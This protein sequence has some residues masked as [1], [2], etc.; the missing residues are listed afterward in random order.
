VSNPNPAVESP[1]ARPQ[2]LARADATDDKARWQAS[3]AAAITAI[4][5]IITEDIVADIN[6]SIAKYKPGARWAASI[7]GIATGIAKGIVADI[8][9]VS[10]DANIT[11]YKAAMVTA[12]VADIAGGPVEPLTLSQRKP[13]AYTGVVK[14]TRQT[15]EK[16]RK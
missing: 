4:T 12:I 5:A 14:K 11:E 2:N 6:L 8:T 1:I 16:D 3:I 9:D 13:P 15:R 10:I 7:A